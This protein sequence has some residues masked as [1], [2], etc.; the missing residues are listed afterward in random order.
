MHWVNF[1]CRRWGHSSNIISTQKQLQLVLPRALLSFARNLT[2]GSPGVFSEWLLNSKILIFR[3]VSASDLSELSPALILQVQT[4]HQN[5]REANVILT[6]DLWQEHSKR[7][8][9]RA[10]FTAKSHLEQN[11]HKVNSKQQETQAWTL[12]GKR[13]DIDFKTKSCKRSLRIISSSTVQCYLKFAISDNS[14]C[15]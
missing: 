1:H 3:T 2:A 7:L 8:T 6:P 13:Q 15:S 5:N 14:A 10:K 12:W 11:R 9:F 4:H